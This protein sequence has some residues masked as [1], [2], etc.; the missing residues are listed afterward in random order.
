MLLLLAGGVSAGIL[1]GFLGVGGGILLMP[2]LRFGWGLSAPLAAGT[3]IMGVFFTTVG[4]SYRHHRLGHAC[5]RPLVPIMLVGGLTT[6]LCSM[7]FPHLA[8]NEQWLDLGIGLVF[9]AIS[10]RM[11]IESLQSP[12]GHRML[13]SDP[14]HAAGSLLQKGIVGGAGGVLPGLL[15]IGTGVVLVPAF[16]YLLR[17]PIKMAMAASLTCF[18]VNALVSST[19]KAVQGFVD[20]EVAW[21]ICLGTLAGANLGAVFNKHC[22]ARSVKLTCGIFFAVV[23]CRFIF[24]CCEASQ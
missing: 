13:D 1:G 24:S 19:A 23:A 15:G 2:I 11:I 4:G 12:P 5:V 6:L 14:H 21:P 20:F 22:P 9:S 3:C 16:R 17:M 18:C 7:L 8:R 10:L